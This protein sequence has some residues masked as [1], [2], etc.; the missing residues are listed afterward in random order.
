MNVQLG[1]AVEC[2]DDQ[3]KSTLGEILIRCNNILYIS[4]IEEADE[5][6]NA[7]A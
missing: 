5:D 7:M 6:E 2:I 4:G 1:N 3:N